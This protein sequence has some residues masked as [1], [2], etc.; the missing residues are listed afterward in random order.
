MGELTQFKEAHQVVPSFNKAKPKEASRKNGLE[1]KAGQ[2]EAAQKKALPAVKV[3]DCSYI[4]GPHGHLL[5]ATSPNVALRLLLLGESASHT[6]ERRD[7]AQESTK[8]HQVQLRKHPD[9]ELNCETT[10]PSVR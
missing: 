9:I 5:T 10:P 1:K 8:R 2:G 7:A 4:E 6:K 3:K